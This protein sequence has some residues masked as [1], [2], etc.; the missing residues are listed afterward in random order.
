MS[1]NLVR[2]FLAIPLGD[3]LKRKL[4]QL[5]RQ[6]AENLPGASWPRP[7]N[8]HLTLRFFGDVTHEDLEKIRVS[9]LSIEGFQQAFEVRVAGLGAFP[10]PRRPRVIW[11]GLSPAALLQ[12]LYLQLQSSLA[13]AGVAQE[14][15]PFKPHLTIGRLRHFGPDM[16]Q[17]IASTGN[18]CCGTLRVDQLVLYQ[19]RLLPG[20]AEHLPLYTL[21]LPSQRKGA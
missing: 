15:R 12:K 20:G 2:A 5:Q 4:T 13:Q 1:Q 6:L 10:H 11:V 19:S 3:E 8:L 21:T 7:D 18:L 9:M 14:A 16:S 17:M